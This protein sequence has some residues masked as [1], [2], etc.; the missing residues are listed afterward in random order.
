VD[1]PTEFHFHQAIPRNRPRD[2]GLSLI[3]SLT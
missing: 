2:S 3:Q 1:F